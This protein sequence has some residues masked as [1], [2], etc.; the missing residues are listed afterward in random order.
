[1][2]YYLKKTN[3]IIFIK[4][5]KMN[6]LNEIQIFL[7]SHN[8][9]RKLLMNRLN[10][11]QIHQVLPFVFLGGIHNIQNKK[12]LDDLKIKTILNMIKYSSK[13]YFMKP[14]YKYFHIGW[15]DDSY[16]SIINDLY[17]IANIIHRN[18]KKKKNILVHCIAG[19]SRS[20]TA[21]VAYMILYLQMNVD[22]SYDLLY[23]KRCVVDCS[24]DNFKG[25]MIL[26]QE[27]VFKV[28]GKHLQLTLPFFTIN[29]IN[30]IQEYLWTH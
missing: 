10:E 17:N 6:K 19:A 23:K 22:Y 26:F 27:K 28:Y 7:L 9:E 2:Y 14:Y 25:Q 21:I 29:F 15:D 16:Q 18:V 20:P 1:V 24:N 30:L 5:L 11:T 4:L 3:L 8:L 12:Y 13:N